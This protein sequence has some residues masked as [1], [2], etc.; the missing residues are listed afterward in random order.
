MI[1]EMLPTYQITSEMNRLPKKAWLLRILKPS[2]VWMI[3]TALFYFVRPDFYSLKIPW[4]ILSFLLFTLI[5]MSRL[6]SSYQTRYKLN[7]TCVQFKTGGFN[8]RFFLSKRKKISELQLTRHI[9]QQKLGL[10]SIVISNRAKP[11]MHTRVNHLPIE[12][13]KAFDRWYMLKE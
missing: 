10:T 9:V 6:L 12:W 7:K 13:C 8:T 1:E 3:A 4:W 11:V 5:M 2:W